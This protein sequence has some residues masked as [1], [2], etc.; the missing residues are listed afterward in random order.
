MCCINRL[1]LV[2]ILFGNVPSDIRAN[3]EAPRCPSVRTCLSVVPWLSGPLPQKILVAG[4]PNAGASLVSGGPFDGG[5]RV[6]ITMNPL[7][8]DGRSLS[9]QCVV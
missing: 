3:V 8:R 6:V 4:S 7:I 5:A 2:P 1:R 9:R